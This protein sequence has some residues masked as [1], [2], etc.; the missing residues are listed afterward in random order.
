MADSAYIILTSD[1]AT[2]NGNFFIDDE[3]LASNDIVDLK[4]YQV[5]QN[6][7]FKCLTPD[8]FLW[9]TIF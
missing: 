1:S 6:L 3:V 2:T 5:D 4:K 7:N 8:F 9:L